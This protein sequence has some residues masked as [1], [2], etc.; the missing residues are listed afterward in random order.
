MTFDFS[1]SKTYDE[2]KWERLEKQRNERRAI[3]RQYEQCLNVC[4]NGCR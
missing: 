4:F 2:K 3:E 1:F